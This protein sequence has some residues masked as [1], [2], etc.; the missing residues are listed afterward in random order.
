M[1]IDILRW[2]LQTGSLH[3]KESTLLIVG[4]CEWEMAGEH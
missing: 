1:G 2:E 3:P 4:D